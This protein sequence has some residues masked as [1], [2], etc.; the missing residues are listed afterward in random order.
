MLS[1]ED[2]EAGK[3][4]V[5]YCEADH[6]YTYF[7]TENDPAACEKCGGK[8]SSKVGFQLTTQRT[9]DSSKMSAEQKEVRRNAGHRN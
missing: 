1:A 6:W 8:F 4:L 7:N 9:F 5:G 2:R 3:N